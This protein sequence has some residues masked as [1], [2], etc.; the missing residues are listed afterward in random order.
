MHTHFEYISLP[1]VRRDQRKNSST[2]CADNHVAHC[3]QIIINERKQIVYAAR[4]ELCVWL[5]ATHLS[6]AGW[7]KALYRN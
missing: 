5:L 6:Y 2:E 1:A 7:R 3:I 4:Y